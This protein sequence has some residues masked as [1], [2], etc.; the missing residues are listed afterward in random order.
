MKMNIVE[1]SVKGLFGIFDHAIP[2]RN[3]DSVTV[4]HGPNGIGKTMLLKLI[5]G[6][7]EG[8]VT[9][10]SDIP[11][12][13]FSARRNDGA[14]LT[15]I[16]S[17]FQKQQTEKHP[18]IFE[19][20]ARD[21]GGQIMPEHSQSLYANIPSDVLDDIDTHVHYEYS[22]RGVGWAKSGESRIYS[23]YEMLK[24]FPE[25]EE[26]VPEEYRLNAFGFFTEGLKV[27]YVETLRLSAESPPRKE[28]DIF[29]EAVDNSETLRVKQ[30]SADVSSR[31]EKALA[32]YAK[33]SQ[34]LDRTFPE[35]LVEF[36]RKDV[37]ALKSTEIIEELSLLDKRRNRLMKLGLLDSES[38]LNNIGEE[39]VRRCSEALTIYIK[40]MKEKLS[41]FD[42][43]AGQTG[44]LMDI[45]NKRF[46]YKQLSLHRTQG[47]QF[48]SLT[49]ASIEIS[50]LSSGEQH[51]LVLLYELLFR[52][53]EKSLI[54][55]D[56]PEISLHVAWQASFL[57]DLMGILK[58][59]NSYGVV[60]THSPTLIGP[61]W[62]LTTKLSGPDLPDVEES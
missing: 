2:L 43:I 44:R 41:V 24:V 25:I 33:F 20:V 8:R 60:A 52:I 56:E 32:D 36:L 10:F 9:V 49:G 27:F 61:R 47:F 30:Y 35:R 6:F 28:Y 59:T 3:A 4:I 23:L 1:F 17:R 34:R 11:F 51:E 45:L 21:S 14:T 53:P 48:N 38:V 13:E 18:V 55:I 62:D 29:D 5:K 50:D 19:V 31:I 37:A 54:L 39:D 7:V 46:K 15:L 57:G 40:D 58:S 16:S 22:R 12:N 26:Y 42:Q